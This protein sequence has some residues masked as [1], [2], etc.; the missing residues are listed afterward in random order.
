MNYFLFVIKCRSNV[1]QRKSWEKLL[2]EADYEV[3]TG[4]D[5]TDFDL[6]SLEDATHF[7]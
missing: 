2:T 7:I 6:F 4:L 3:F 5:L 1:D